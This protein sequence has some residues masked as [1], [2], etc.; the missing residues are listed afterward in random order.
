MDAIAILIARYQAEDTNSLNDMDTSEKPNIISALEDY[1]N[2]DRV[3]AFLLAITG[4]EKEFDLARIE[5]LKVLG[6]QGY[7]SQE[8][9]NRVGSVLE[10]VLLYSADGDVRIYAALAAASYLDIDAVFQAID[11]ILRNNDEESNLRWSAFAAI[12]RDGRSSRAVNLLRHLL[13]D[14]E[15]KQSAERV[16]SELNVD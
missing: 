7:S 12:K 9:R 4:D 15:F 14:P 1:A 13:A 11:R 6:V 10:H 2:D 8:I 16:L 5:A 3:V